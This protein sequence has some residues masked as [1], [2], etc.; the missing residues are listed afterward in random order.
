MAQAEIGHLHDRPDKPK[1]AHTSEQ[2]LAKMAFSGVNWR[3]RQT[4]AKHDKQ[5]D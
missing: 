3:C 1:N 2:Q 5:N 4:E